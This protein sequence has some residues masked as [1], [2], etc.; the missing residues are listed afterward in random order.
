MRNTTLIFRLS[1][2]FLLVT[3]SSSAYGG[4]KTVEWTASEAG[5][6]NSE[7]LDEVT[8]AI[9]ET[10]SVIF[11]T[12]SGSNQPAY[13]DSGTSVRLYAGNSMT[14]RGEG[15]IGITLTFGSGDKTNG[16]TANCGTYTPEGIWTGKSNVVTFTVEG[17]SGHRRIAGIA[18]TYETD[19]PDNP[20]DHDKP[21][22]LQTVYSIQEFKSL[23][24]G[25]SAQLYLSDEMNARVIHKSPGE[26]YLRDKSGAICLTL[27]DTLYNPIPAHNQ[28]VAGY[29]TGRYETEQ[30]LP[31]FVA[32]DLTETEYMLFADQVSEPDTKPEEI[33]VEEFGAYYADWVTLTGMHVSHDGDD[34]TIDYDDMYFSVVN[35]FGL[36]EDDLYSTPPDGSTVN[37]TGIAIPSD[38]TEQIAPI[39]INP[40]LPIEVTE[41]PPSH[42]KGDVNEDGKVDISDIVAV[43]NQIAGTATYR[44]ADVNEDNKV[45]ISD[46]VA[47]INIIAEGDTISTNVAGR[48]EAVQE[49]VKTVEPA[50]PPADPTFKSLTI[51]FV[52]GTTVTLTIDQIESITYIPDIG[53][54]IHLSGTG[55][56]L[57]FLYSQIVKIEYV[58]EEE[59]Q[60]DDN[61]NANWK[62]FDLSSTV[63]GNLRYAYR[64]EYP[65]LNSNQYSPSNKG[66]NQVVVKETSDYGITFSLEWDNTQIANRWT[67]YTLH[68]RNLQQIVKRNDS[69]KAD[70]D[71]AN[72]AQLGDY[73]SSGYSRGHL[74]PSADRLCSREQNSQTFFLTNMQPQWQSHNGGLW[75]RMEDMVRDWAGDCDTLYVVKAATIG[76]VTLD[77]KVTDG[78]YS[79]KCNG[80]LPVPRYF[81]MAV[82]AYSRQ[83]DSYEA[84]GLWTVHENAND[85][86]KN[87]G[88]YAIT[89]DELERR[90]GIDFFCNLPD[91]MENKVESTLNLSYW[92]ISKS[93]GK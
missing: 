18:V 51:Y 49:V 27:A 26:V 48:K 8:A 70:P 50:G 75:G 9:D 72:S 46:I 64:L 53:M 82:L 20:D 3:L 85:S 65:H 62:E 17:S 1:L 32:T 71:V 38:T 15:I 47:V 63:S 80:R 66:G 90:T 5:Y 33:D 73:S 14:V 69:F 40:Y 13:Y 44:Y 57:D 54:K 23:S 68:A 6:G 56:C 81:Y 78:I 55:L 12:G 22:T 83:T 52:N 77:G 21:D 45:D 41:L 29:M 24:E 28:H 4:E 67:C 92:G 11:Y 10:T 79:F 59:I 35:R 25:T 58:Y 89:I 61:A 93:S 37:I 19:D 86:N 2:L 76:D 43:I 42:K 31:L 30:G 91:H 84:I 74:C 60:E 7:K 88:D 39:Y 87:Y 16:I 34:V 36:G